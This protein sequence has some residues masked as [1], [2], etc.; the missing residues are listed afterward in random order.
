MSWK[1]FLILAG[2]I[3]GIIILVFISSI[4]KG[5]SPFKE[6]YNG[7]FEESIIDENTKEKK[8]K[9]KERTFKNKCKAFFY[10]IWIF[11]SMVVLAPLML[12]ALLHASCAGCSNIHDGGIE[13]GG[14]LSPH[15]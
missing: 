9:Y 7:Y 1:S 8:V 15:W 6:F 3:S 12:S 14:K 13:Y 11:I 10:T 2:I 4:I 5:K